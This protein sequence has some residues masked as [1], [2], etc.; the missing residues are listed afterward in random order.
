MTQPD[1]Y[2]WG[3]SNVADTDYF[4]TDG[5]PMSTALKNNGY[6]GADKPDN[7]D[8]NTLFRNN[9]L[10]QQYLFAREK[11]SEKTMLTSTGTA[12]WNGSALTLSQNL[13]FSFRKDDGKQVNRI[14]AGTL[15]FTDGHVL[16]ISRDDAAASPVVLASV[17]YGSLTAGSYALVAETSLTAADMEYQTVIFRRN[18]S[19]L[20]CPILDRI[21]VSGETISFSKI[22]ENVFSAASSLDFYSGKDLRF[23]SDAGSTLKAAIDGATGNI[24]IAS[25]SKFFISGA[26]ML[27][28][29]YI[30]QP[31]ANLAMIATS[32]IDA[33]GIYGS[34]GIGIAST[35]RV[36]WDGVGMSGDTYTTHSSSNILD[37]YV[38]GVLQFR[39]TASSVSFS[40][41]LT[42]GHDPATGADSG[43]FSPFLVLNAGEATRIS[44]LDFR[45]LGVQK[46]K[47]AY[48]HDST[49][50]NELL[51]LNVAG[52]EFWWTNTYF[53]PVSASTTMSLGDSGSNAH[54]NN[55]HMFGG[56]SFYGSAT[57]TS[58]DAT[59][60]LSGSGIQVDGSITATADITATSGLTTLAKASSILSSFSVL[61]I[62]GENTRV[63][64]ADAYGIGFVTDNGTLDAIMYFDAA[65]VSTAGAGSYYGKSPV[66]VSGVGFKYM[67]LFN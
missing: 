8:H 23:Y 64:P 43:A 45:A 6:A 57:D 42:I 22:F 53:G 65:Y 4:R 56:I 16:V 12:T 11:S 58:A 52:K 5:A 51:K 66:Y 36:N 2:N 39:R 60:S 63:A 30:Y 19:T 32:G 38:G 40:D 13:D 24:G 54:W 37:D 21:W 59:I 7:Q 18:G 10:W 48:Q 50:A 17:A 47:F 27:G 49:Q 44:T 26:D 29:T 55:L 33:L 1:S 20:E 41:T 62:S 61:K 9:Y 14:A 35:K 28:S 15:S 67:H 34:D 46:G 31:S 25:G 3:V